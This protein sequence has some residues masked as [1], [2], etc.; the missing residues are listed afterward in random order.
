MSAIVDEGLT[1]VLGFSA[2]NRDYRWAPTSAESLPHLAFGLAV[3]V[4]TETA[5]AVL[6]R[7]P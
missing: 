1:P 2:P 4:A 7:R 3:A 6:R 5:W